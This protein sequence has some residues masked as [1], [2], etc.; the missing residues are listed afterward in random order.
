MEFDNKGR[1]ENLIFTRLVRGFHENLGEIRGSGNCVKLY[2][3]QVKHFVN[4]NR[5]LT[6]SVARIAVGRKYT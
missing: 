2:A 5:K 3:D 4:E 1:K 6:F